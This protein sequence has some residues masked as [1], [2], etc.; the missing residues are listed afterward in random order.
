MLSSLLCQFEAGKSNYLIFQD[1]INL[2][3]QD[4]FNF[5]FQDNLN[6]LCQDNFNLL[7]QDNFKCRNI[8]SW[9][10]VIA[11]HSTTPH[12]TVITFLPNY[13]YFL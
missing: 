9:D 10:E 11:Q 2:L 13:Y 1:K 8:Y 5:L 6:L 7:F 4:N 3:F 12:H